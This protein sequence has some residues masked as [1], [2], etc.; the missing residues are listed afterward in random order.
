VLA[1][2]AT[3][4]GRAVT[5]AEAYVRA[6]IYYHYDK[7]LFAGHADEW[8]AAHDR[9]V[10][11][12]AARAPGLDPPLQRLTFPYQGVAIPGWLRKPRESARP[13]VAIL[14][15]RLEET[16]AARCRLESELCLVQDWA[17]AMG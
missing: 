1:K 14:L 2:E 8:R 11:C 12:Y 3:D 6:A 15:P 5:A 16:D 17:K 13:P 7:H 4:K 9:V 10:R